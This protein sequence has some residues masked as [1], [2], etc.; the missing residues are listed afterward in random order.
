M[1]IRYRFS[2]RK[3]PLNPNQ[4]Q[5]ILQAVSKGT[6]DVET[7]AYEISN[8]RSLSP[9]DVHAFLMVLGTKIQMHLCDGK[10]VNSDHLGKYKIGLKN[11]S[12]LESN[13]LTKKSIEKFY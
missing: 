11:K 3:N 6:V 9:V 12:Q 8:E 1:A 2:K 5:H 4:V 7:I 10:I 13:L